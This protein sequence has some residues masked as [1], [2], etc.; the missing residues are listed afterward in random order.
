MSDDQSKEAQLFLIG[1]IISLFV[2]YPA[3]VVFIFLAASKYKNINPG[4]SK[5]LNIV[6]ITLTV[7]SLVFTLA[8]LSL[9]MGW[10]F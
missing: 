3:G 8:V 9:Y 10:V 5:V 7:G 4:L 2:V 1:G 6:A